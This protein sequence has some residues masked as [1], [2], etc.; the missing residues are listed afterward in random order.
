MDF[1]AQ[2]KRTLANG[3]NCNGTGILVTRTLRHPAYVRGDSLAPQ[4]KSVI[5]LMRHEPFFNRRRGRSCPMASTRSSEGQRSD[6][7]ARCNCDVV[8]IE[9][10]PEEYATRGHCSHGSQSCT[11]PEQDVITR[12]NGD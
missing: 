12:K 8:A 3:L 7:V 4:K 10:N 5:E 1:L 6:T 9:E 2:N 11:A